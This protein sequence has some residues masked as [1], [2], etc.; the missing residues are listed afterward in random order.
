LFSSFLTVAGFTSRG[1][2]PVC[3]NRRSF[4]LGDVEGGL[5]TITTCIGAGCG[6]NG[7]C[8]HGGYGT[9]TGG[10][11]GLGKG[12]GLIGIIGF[13]VKETSSFVGSIKRIV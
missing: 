10:G 6:G 2:R 8:G 12:S 3:V 7:G 9:G 13:Q 5:L 4:V 11:A 1:I